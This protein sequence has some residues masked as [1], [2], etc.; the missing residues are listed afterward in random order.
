MRWRREAAVGAVTPLVVASRTVAGRRG[1]VRRITPQ[2]AGG[3]RRYA[4]EL[5]GD[6]RA[7]PG[8]VDDKAAVLSWPWW[9][10]QSSPPWALRVFVVN[11]ASRVSDG[12]LFR[13]RC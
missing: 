12:D 8:T 11:R 10:W 3:G 9:C 13:R 2:C 1:L 4:R 5:Y 6:S 7:V